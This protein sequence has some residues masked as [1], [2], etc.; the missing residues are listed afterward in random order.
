MPAELDLSMIRGAAFQLHNKMDWK[1]HPCIMGCGR[2]CDGT[3]PVNGNDEEVIEAAFDRGEIKLKTI[4]AAQRRVNNGTTKCGFLNEKK[5]CTIYES[6]PA[7]CA[8]TGAGGVPSSAYPETKHA[9]EN[10]L[11]TGANEEI[12]A[13]KLVSS[14]CPD[15]A[16]EMSRRGTT[17]SA[18]TIAAYVLIIECYGALAPARQINNFIQ[19]LKID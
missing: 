11:A 1:S 4:K 10:M 19:D 9:V 3:T 6:R 17:F 16:T 5:E 8:V 2:C 18:K 12:P 7:I 13:A 14:M 15:C